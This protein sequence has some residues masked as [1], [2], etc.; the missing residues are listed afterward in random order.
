MSITSVSAAAWMSAKSALNSLITDANTRIVTSYTGSVTPAISLEAGQSIIS[1][2]IVSGDIIKADDYSD[3]DGLVTK[4]N[5]MRKYDSARE[6]NISGV[7]TYGLTVSS[8][9]LLGR[10][11][12]SFPATT[13]AYITPPEV[14]DDI[15]NILGTSTKDILEIVL[16]GASIHRSTILGLTEG[17]E[18]VVID[19]CHSS[20]HSSCHGRCNR[21]KR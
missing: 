2:S 14:G 8:A 16:A 1:R 12:S 18:Y 3:S 4:Y 21:S 9:G 5:A 19:N 17:T 13:P 7:W 10:R 20:C 6:R 15:E 11:D